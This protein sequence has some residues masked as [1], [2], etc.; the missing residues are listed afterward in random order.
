[1][2]VVLRLTFCACCPGSASIIRNM[3]F[4]NTNTGWKLFAKPH[5]DDRSK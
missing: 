2:T 4:Y 3:G 1:M 5:F